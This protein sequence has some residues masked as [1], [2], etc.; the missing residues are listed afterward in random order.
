M[1]PRSTTCQA[2]LCSSTD[3]SVIG[4]VSAWALTPKDAGGVLFDLFEQRGNSPWLDEVVDVEAAVAVA[5]V[6][7]P[8]VALRVELEAGDFLAGPLV[9]D[10]VPRWP[11]F[12]D[13][14]RLAPHCVL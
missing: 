6:E 9:A 3:K 4:S 5:P 10:T 8:F 2:S 14:D 11:S 1:R 12:D 7:G 13:R